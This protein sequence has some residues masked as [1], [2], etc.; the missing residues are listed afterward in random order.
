LKNKKTLYENLR[1]AGKLRHLDQGP[2]GCH[3]ALALLVNVAVNAHKDRYDVKDGW[4][5]V[6]CEGQFK[7]GDQVFPDLRLKIRLEPGDLVL[8]H[9]AV[10]EHWVED[11]VEGQ[12]YCH[13]RFTKGNILR[14]HTPKFRCRLEGCNSAFSEERNLKD[15]L[16]R[17]TKKQYHG[18]PLDEVDSLVKAWRALKDQEELPE[19]DVAKDGAGVAQSGDS[20]V[21]AG[22][23]DCYE[24]R[25]RNTGSSLSGRC[26][27]DMDMDFLGVQ[28]T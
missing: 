14:P 7:G 27:T 19:E 17:S 3:A 2:N 6:N 9:Y 22:K 23:I 28:D 12:R 16:R 11:V 26:L 1:Q 8:A 20:Q 25:V 5:E 15:H 21:D 13:V 24:E 18:L 10:L 4:T